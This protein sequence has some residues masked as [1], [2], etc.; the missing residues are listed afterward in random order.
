MTAESA[1]FAAG[2]ILY[3]VV[4]RNAGSRHFT[5]LSAAAVAVL[6]SFAITITVQLIILLGR[7]QSISH[8]FSVWAILTEILRFTFAALVFYKVRQD[9]D[10]YMGY[11]GWGSLGIILVFG[12]APAIVQRLAIWF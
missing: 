7:D 8:L 6:G 12:I 3:L 10:S 11:L 5:P 1:A 4:L 2:L 9:E